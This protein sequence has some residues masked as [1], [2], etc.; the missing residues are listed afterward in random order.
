MHK[1][2]GLFLLLDTTN[3]LWKKTIRYDTLNTV[4]VIGYSDR[5]SN[6]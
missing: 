1:R 3:K 4:I 2:E 6:Y 5:D